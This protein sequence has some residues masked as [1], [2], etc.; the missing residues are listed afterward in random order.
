MKIHYQRLIFQ[1]PDVEIDIF[2]AIRGHPSE[3][4]A[5]CF[6]QVGQTVERAHRS[7]DFPEAHSG[8]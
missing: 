7:S 3:L 6:E 1:C 2:R 5:I 4:V 8:F